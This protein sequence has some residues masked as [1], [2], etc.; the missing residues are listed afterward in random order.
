MA[1]KRVNVN[2]CY[3]PVATSVALGN[4]SLNFCDFCEEL[5]LEP[6]GRV[7]AIDYALA[8]PSGAWT[9]IN[10]VLELLKDPTLT[11]SQRHY[12]P[13][14]FACRKGYWELVPKLISHPILGVGMNSND[15]LVEAAAGNHPI[16]VNQLIR[17][18]GADPSIDDNWC[19]KNA[20]QCG[21]LAVAR[22]LLDDPRVDP[23]D[24]L[25]E[26]TQSNNI[27]LVRLILDHPK[28]EE[29]HYWFDVVAAACNN[30]NSQLLE[31]VI[32]HKRFSWTE[33]YDFR[34][35]VGLCDGHHGVLVVLMDHFKVNFATE[36]GS[37]AV[38]A[39]RRGWFDLAEKLHSDP[40]F[41]A[42]PEQ[43]EYIRTTLTPPEKIST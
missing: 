10:V 17:Y 2:S 19:L 24:A 9:H 29:I 35:V 34:R 6:R 5:G 40:R 41:S 11:P 21:R 28:A 32:N 4:E 3:D 42:T 1:D 27:E 15:L 38:E 12:S 30:A 25:H 23:F 13:L 37:I 8:P 26:A 22:V 7:A 16:I 31:L 20:T 43:K 14:E 33:N 39:C 18:Y 36:A